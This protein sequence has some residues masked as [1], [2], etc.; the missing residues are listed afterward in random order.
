MPQPDLKTAVKTVRKK[1]EDV[2]GNLTGIREE[3]KETA[4]TLLPPRLG[5]LRQRITKR[6]ESLK[7]RLEQTA[8]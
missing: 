6:R 1:L 7:E 4:T 5:M 2:K 3:V 8:R